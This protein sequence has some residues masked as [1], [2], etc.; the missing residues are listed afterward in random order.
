M[1]LRRHSGRWQSGALMLAL[2]ALLAG[3]ALPSL[4]P[5]PW[6]HTSRTPLPAAQQVAHVAMLT[7]DDD[8]RTLDPAQVDYYGSGTTQIV[9]L[10]Y[11]GLFTLDAHLRPAPALATSYSVSA[12]GLRYTFHLRAGARFAE[13]TPLTSADVAFSLNRVMSGCLPSSNPSGVFAD[14]NDQ[15]AFLQMCQ[16]GPLHKHPAVT[17][18]IGVSLLAPDPSTFVMVLAQPDDALISKLAEPYS[19][20]VEQSLVTRYG[21]QWIEHLAEG[22]G[23]GTSGM[24]SVAAWTP[25][26][27]QQDGSRLDGSL[28]LRVAPGY[29]GRQPLLRQV[30]IALRSLQSADIVTTSPYPSDFFALKPSDEI[31]FDAFPPD[32]LT[33]QAAAR[34]LTF[35]TAPTRIVDALALDAHTAPLDD[36]RLRQALA[37]A[38]DKTQIATIDRGVATNHLIP[39]GT[40][41]YPATLSGPIATAPL[42]GDAA[43][44][45]ALWQ[46]Y[47]Q[48]RCGGV[49][50]RCPTITAF[51]DGQFGMTP[52]EPA[53]L[54]RWRMTLP[55][56]RFKQVVYGGTLLTTTPPPPA[57]TYAPWL[58]NYPDPQ[59]WLQSYTNVPGY[60]QPPYDVHD[61]QADALV[62]RAEV[63]RNP[64]RA[65][66]ALS[67]SG[68]H[69]AQRRG[70][71]SHR[72][73]AGWLGRQ[74][75]RRQLPRRP[76]AVDRARRLGAH[77]PDGASEDMNASGGFQRPL[78]AVS[79]C[80]LSGGSSRA[81][82]S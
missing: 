70:G 74:V 10:L 2:A 19:L 56:I 42:T 67:A 8:S 79:A 5:L 12:D 66:S 76:R 6:Q 11:S 50:S 57:V 9:S 20:I 43:Q 80:A 14:V 21:A 51:D 60:E 13:G 48:D 38:L 15:P 7:A 63:T 82:V 18:L 41:A 54:A 49:A 24:Y 46:S 25:P 71:Y 35:S 32:L 64:C 59:D 26:A 72:A 23:Q 34:G 3:C 68:E 31:V 55:G 36:P 47:V 28:T 78:R 73:S 4:P 61:A 44:A 65:A 16:G 1:A 77:L 37:L 27:R 17:T 53:V 81:V 45:Q 30:D 58:E 22:G 33:R 40:G 75:Q 39:P 69:A 52:L 62:A 29:W